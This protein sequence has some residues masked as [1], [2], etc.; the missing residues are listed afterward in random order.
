VS[1]DAACGVGQCTMTL[2]YIV[3]RIVGATPLASMRNCKRLEGLTF[4]AEVST[5]GAERLELARI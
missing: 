4:R 3:K 1:L 2:E 5:S